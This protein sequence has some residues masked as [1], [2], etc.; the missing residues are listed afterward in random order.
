MF[1]FF[2]A[3]YLSHCWRYLCKTADVYFA[4]SIEGWVFV[5]LTAVGS[6]IHSNHNALEERLFV[7]NDQPSTNYSETGLL[8]LQRTSDLSCVTSILV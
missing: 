4:G 1:R 5:H 6:G 7:L 2:R 8:R 3:L